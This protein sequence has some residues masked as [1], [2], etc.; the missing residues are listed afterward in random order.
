MK[1]VDF[2]EDK[3]PESLK[4][5]KFFIKNQQIKIYVFTDLVGGTI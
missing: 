5:N 2:T 4:G 3:S 1:P